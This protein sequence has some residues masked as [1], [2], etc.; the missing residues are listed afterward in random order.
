M[1]FQFTP[2]VK[3]LLIINI[4][5]FIISIVGLQYLRIDIN[6][7][8]GLHSWYS[9]NFKPWQFVTYMFMHSYWDQYGV[10][11]GHVLRN[12]FALLVFGPMLEERWG[13]KRFLFFYLFTGIGAGL[14]YWGVNTYETTAI[15]KQGRFL[16]K[17]AQVR[18]GF[19]N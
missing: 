16:Y 15:K 19:R 7:I 18:R 3:N 17:P 1:R 9:D 8:F 2:M 5:I 12:M 4:G 11:F 10:S 14:L 13:V 6:E